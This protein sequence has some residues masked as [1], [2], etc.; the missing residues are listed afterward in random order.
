M[1][2]LAAVVAVLLFAGA[3]AAHTGHFA[4]SD[5]TDTQPLSDTL[6]ELDTL[7]A[8]YNENADSL[9]SLV[10]R[11]IAGERINVHIDT[12]EDEVVVGAVLDGARVART[13]RGGIGNATVEF[14]TD[15]ERVR[16]ALAAENPREHALAAFNSG[17]ITYDTKGFGR[18]VKFAVLS[19]VSK[20]IGVLL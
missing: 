18:A 6:D 4:D 3:A 9:P 10:K 2:L 8:S 1:R 15:E 16:G 13:E 17:R 7:V 12:A 11:L 19:T 14:Y 5:T 20:V